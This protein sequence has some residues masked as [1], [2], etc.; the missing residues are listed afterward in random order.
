MKK[1]KPAKWKETF[2]FHVKDAIQS[3]LNQGLTTSQISEVLQDMGPNISPNDVRAMIEVYNLKH[4]SSQ[5]D[6]WLIP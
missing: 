5:L 3:M 2:T 1:V 6:N 4:K